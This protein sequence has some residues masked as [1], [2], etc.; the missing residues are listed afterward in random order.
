MPEFL[1]LEGLA[2][3]AM[4]V[5]LQAVLGFD[6]LLY[7]SIE[8]RRA[9][10]AEQ[11]RVRRYGV[12]LAII[13]RL[14]LLFVILT[15]L[16]SFN[17]PLFSVDLGW[18]SGD[19]TLETLIM[20]AGGVFI[21]YMAT[22]EIAHML[23]IDKLSADV[24]RAGQKSAAEAM[25]MIVIMNLVFSFD[26]IL[27]ATALTRDFSTLALAVVI[28]GILMLALADHVADFLSRHRLYEVLGLFILLIVGILLLS[29]GGEKAGLTF[30][31]YSVEKMSKTTFYFSVVVLVLLELAQTRYKQKLLTEKQSEMRRGGVGAPADKP[32]VAPAVREAMAQVSR[33]LRRVSG[34]AL[35]DDEQAPLTDGNSADAREDKG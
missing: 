22:K 35:A 7:V 33:R 27:S 29:D 30:F 11:A 8:S 6:N 31:G 9:P 20:I 13:M 32:A 14:V 4:L 23:V 15:L 2:T 34:P 19:F 16:E 10:P 24:E 28:G 26:S 18:A 21:M 3:L 12:G 5:F 25:L 17:A 1:T